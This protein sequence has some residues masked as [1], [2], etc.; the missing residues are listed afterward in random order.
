GTFTHTMA[1]GFDVLFRKVDV[2]LVANVANALLC[3]VPRLAGKQVA[4]NV[5]GVEWERSKWGP[6]GRR[7]FH[8]NARMAGRI[9]PDGIITDAIAMQRIY[10]DQFDT[11]SACIAYGANI[12]TASDPDVVRRYG[13]EPRGYYLIASRMVPENNADLIVRGFE[14]LKSDRMLA[15]AGDANYRS[16]FLDELKKTRDP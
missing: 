3:A 14:R 9:C 10:R 16:A 6:I 1:C 15:I 5:D 4:L 2:M 13:L 11:R 12:E 8:W 7:Y